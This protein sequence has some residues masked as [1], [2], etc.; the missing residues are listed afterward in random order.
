MKRLDIS[1][2]EKM[3]EAQQIETLRLSGKPKYEK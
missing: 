2:P 3:L 1:D